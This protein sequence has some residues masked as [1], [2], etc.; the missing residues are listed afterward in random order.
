MLLRTTLLISTTAAI[1]TM[2]VG[3]SN[4]QTSDEAGQRYKAMLEQLNPSNAPA[5]ARD[6]EGGVAG[7]C[8]G[9]PANATCGG[10]ADGLKFPLSQGVWAVVPFSAN[11]AQGSG[12]ANANDPCQRND[13]DFAQAGVGMPAVP[14]NFDFYGTI[15]TGNQIFINNN[16][17]LSFGAGFT[18]FTAAGFP[19]N[20]FPMVAP[21]WGDV[22]T[23][24]TAA[25]PNSG[26]VWYQYRDDNGDANIE[27]LVVTWENVGYYNVQSGKLNTFQVAISDGTNPLMGLGNN[28]CFSYDKMCWTTGSASGGAGGFGG[29]PATVGANKGNGIDFFQIGR[30]DAPGNQYNGPVNPS[31]VEWLD[32]QDL[33]FNTS[34]VQNI[35]PIAIGLPPNNKITVDAAAGQCINQLVQFIGPEGGQTVTVQVNDPN[36]AQA[37]GLVVGNNPGNPAA[38]TLQWCPDCADQGSYTIVLVATDNGVPAE[39]TTVAIQLNVNCPVVGCPA[40]LNGDGIVNGADLGILLANWGTNLAGD[41]I[42]PAGVGPEDLAILIAAWGPCP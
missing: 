28:I 5:S 17:N 18:T 23:R 32:G 30:F 4:R 19:I 36:G 35:P 21:F 33:C 26:V 41:F 40:D 8:L 22:D 15:F 34:F 1:A 14:F 16:G 9:N 24:V 10:D 39:S 3:A 38:V 7:A 27:T 6:S 31:G 12:P 42:P 25:N 20:N 2:A 11:G 37:A 29:T 13:D